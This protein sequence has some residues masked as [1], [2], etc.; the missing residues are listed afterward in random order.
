MLQKPLISPLLLENSNMA[1]ETSKQASQSLIEVSEVDWDSGASQIVWP[2]P[3]KST[4]LKAQA[5]EFHK[6]QDKGHLTQ[7]LLFRK[8]VKGFEEQESILASDELRI[9]SLEA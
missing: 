2:I 9:E 3:K 5:A 7:R 1:K 6:L 4:T 8:I